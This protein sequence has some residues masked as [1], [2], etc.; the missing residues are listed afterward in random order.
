MR[1]SYWNYIENMIF[2]LGI[3]EPDQQKFNKQPKNVY[4][5]PSTFWG[6]MLLMSFSIPFLEIEMFFMIGCVLGPL[7]GISVFASDEK[8]AWNCLFKILAF[9]VHQLKEDKHHPANYRPISLTC[10]SC[11]LLEHVMATNM[12]EHLESSNILYEM[13]HGLR[14]LDV[15]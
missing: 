9:S 7:S 3:N 10:I 12:M 6:L 8:A 1:N 15:Y 11:K 4:S 5:G 2:D 13:Q 14:S